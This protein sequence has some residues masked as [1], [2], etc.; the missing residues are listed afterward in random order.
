MLRALLGQKS[1]L[2]VNP[3][4]LRALHR[5]KYLWS[6]GHYIKTSMGA[7]GYRRNDG[8][9]MCRSGDQG[10]TGENAEQAAEHGIR[11][12]VVKLPDTK[13]GFVSLCLIRRVAT[14]RSPHPPSFSPAYRG[15]CG[16]PPG[17]R[18]HKT[19]SRAQA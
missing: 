9:G 4:E 13:R 3:L 8:R 16:Y 1:K 6:Y 7:S 19:T 17:A 15:R 12:G 2:P 14:L 10:Y 18:L 5:W 11:L